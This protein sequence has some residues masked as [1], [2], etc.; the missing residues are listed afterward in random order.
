MGN[1]FGGCELT[2]QAH[3]TRV[4]KLGRAKHS[5]ALPCCESSSGTANSFGAGNRLA[6]DDGLTNRLSTR[7]P[8]C[9]WARQVW[10]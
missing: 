2:R 5:T 4:P 1:A 8:C 3:V 7:G 9:R 10:H 6:Q